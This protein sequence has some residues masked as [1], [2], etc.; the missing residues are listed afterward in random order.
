MLFWLTTVAILILITTL[1]VFAIR[2]AIKEKISDDSLS[3]NF[4]ESICS[5][6]EKYNDIDN[7]P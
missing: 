6:H 2:Q 5:Y 3:T 7:H 1:I 4:A